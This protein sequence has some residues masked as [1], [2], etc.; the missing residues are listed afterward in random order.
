MEK[1]RIEEDNKKKFENVVSFETQAFKRSDFKKIPK[2]TSTA[3][4]S[5]GNH[6]IEPLPSSS[7]DS[8]EPASKERTKRESSL[9]SSSD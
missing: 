2:K 6:N 9:D 4:E 5:S 1:K 7:A 8:G 3:S